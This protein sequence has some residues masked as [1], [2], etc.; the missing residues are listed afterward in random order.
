MQVMLRRYDHGRESPDP[1]LPLLQ[2]QRSLAQKLSLM[3]MPIRLSILLPLSTS[4]VQHG[5]LQQQ[6]PCSA[7]R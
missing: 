7:P 6:P 5:P 1:P 4:L 3:A 2:L